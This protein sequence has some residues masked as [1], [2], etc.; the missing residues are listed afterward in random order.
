MKRWYLTSWCWMIKLIGLWLLIW[1]MEI[2]WFKYLHLVSWVWSKRGSSYQESTVIYT[3]SI[4]TL[5]RWLLIRNRSR[6]RIKFRILRSLSVFSI[7]VCVISKHQ[8]VKIVNAR[9]PEKLRKCSGGRWFMRL[10]SAGWC[11]LKMSGFLF[12]GSNL[13]RNSC[14]IL[15][16]RYLKTN[17]ISH[18][19]QEKED[20]LWLLL[21]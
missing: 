14:L 17:Q 15:R 7:F 5:W 6:W 9:W 21:R 18:Q 20:Y 2:S 19:L 10:R 13:R 11:H 8:H 4:R 16:K 12:M 1:S 3:S